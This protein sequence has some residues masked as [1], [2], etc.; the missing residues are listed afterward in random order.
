MKVSSY[1]AKTNQG[2]YLN[3][4]ED[5][6][7]IDLN[8][9]IFAIFDGFGGSSI[10]DH[11]VELSKNVF[12]SFFTKISNDPEATL[13]FF[14][15][16]QYA[17]ETNALVNALFMAHEELLKENSER[18]MMDRGAVSTCSAM[19]S[20]NTLSLASIGNCMVCLFRDGYLSLLNSPDTLVPFGG[21]YENNISKTFPLS[22]IGLFKDFPV[23]IEEF[24]LKDNDKMIFLSDGAYS[25]LTFEEL[26][27]VA[28]HY[29]KDDKSLAEHLMATTNDRGNLDNQSVIVLSL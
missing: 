13:P 20:G 1:F 19:I 29:S 14:Y 11:A 12:H 6:I 27:G 2:P 15:S 4:N 10:G 25:R 8:N 18:E 17:L 22:A 3:I 9:M 7:L 21:N 23:K 26:E 5:D 24:L 16:E 28:R